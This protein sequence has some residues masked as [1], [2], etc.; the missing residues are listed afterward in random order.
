MACVERWVGHASYLLLVAGKCLGWIH[1]FVGSKGPQ[2]DDEKL[3]EG[4]YFQWRSKITRRYDGMSDYDFIGT[5]R[6]TA[7]GF[8]QHS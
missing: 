6:N 7:R 2:K 3:V 8:Y 4:V 1:R 5:R